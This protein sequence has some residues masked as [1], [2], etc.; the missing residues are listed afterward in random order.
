M[1][2][3]HEPAQWRCEIDVA[4]FHGEWEPGAVPYET[5][6]REGNLLLGGG[7][8]VLWQALIGATG[9][10]TA[11]ANQ[12]LSYFSAAN[13]GIG[14]GDSTTA[15]AVTQNDLQ[16]ATNKLRKVMNGGFPAHTDGTNTGAQS[17]QFQST[18]GT[19]EA[20]WAWEESGVFNSSV[21]ATGRMLNRKVTTLGTKTSSSSWQITFTITIS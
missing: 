21:A 12:T 4:K 17:I 8:G 7:V 15:A 20:N 16:A 2:D 13:A 9:G 5:V 19:A 6:H 10:A 18:F 3:I 14:V 11:T 1:S